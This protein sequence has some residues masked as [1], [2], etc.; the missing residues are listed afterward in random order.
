LARRSREVTH[1]G[2]LLSVLLAITP[3]PIY[4]T[5]E[6][7]EEQIEHQPGATVGAPAR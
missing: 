6:P 7:A 3:V 5:G 1:A 4:L 2:L